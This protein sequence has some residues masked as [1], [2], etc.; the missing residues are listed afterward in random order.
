MLGKGL[1]PWIP[2]RQTLCPVR[3]RHEQ[4]RVAWFGVVHTEGD[5]LDQLEIETAIVYHVYMG[6]NL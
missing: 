6:I 1:V 5:Q 2:V 4:R 3:V